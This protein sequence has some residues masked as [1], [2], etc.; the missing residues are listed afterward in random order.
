MRIFYVTLT[1][2]ILVSKYIMINLKCIYRLTA[3]MKN[4]IFLFGEYL[5]IKI[6]FPYL[7]DNILLISI[8][9]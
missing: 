6:I 7:F 8:S 3:L 4:I 5:L 9:R 1:N 2:E